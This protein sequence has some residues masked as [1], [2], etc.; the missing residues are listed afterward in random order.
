M[1]PAQSTGIF[2]GALPI[3]E[4]IFFTLTNTLIVFGMTLLLSY[5]TV[6]AQLFGHRATQPNTKP[7][8]N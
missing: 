8:S 4:L 1:T 3:E 6:W 5:K 7:T 2:V